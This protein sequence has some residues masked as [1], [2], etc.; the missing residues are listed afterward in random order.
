MSVKMKV[1]FAVICVVAFCLGCSSGSDP[2]AYQAKMVGTA[3]LIHNAARAC[4]NQSRTYAAALQTAEVSGKDSIPE[5]VIDKAFEERRKADL[6]EID[7]AMNELAKEVPQ[8]FLG[9]YD[10]LVSFY[11]NYKRTHVNLLHPPGT[12]QIYFDFIRKIE[13]E[14]RTKKDALDQSLPKEQ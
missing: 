13:P 8:G 5:Y 10:A 11:D 9:S 1:S 6:S 14:I 2:A 7:A 12:S 4:L 3:E